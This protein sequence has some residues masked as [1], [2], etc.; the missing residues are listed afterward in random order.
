M[1]HGCP[2]ALCIHWYHITNPQKYSHSHLRHINYAI[3]WS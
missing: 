3:S 2:L 1:H